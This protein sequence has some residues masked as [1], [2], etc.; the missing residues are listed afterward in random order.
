LA[1]LAAPTGSA[2]STGSPALA[3][4]RSA[5]APPALA[6]PGWEVIEDVETGSGNGETPKALVKFVLLSSYM[7]LDHAIC[8]IKRGNSVIAI[9][10]DPGNS[11]TGQQNL[12]SRL[13]QQIP[14]QH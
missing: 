8:P 13:T 10:N 4:S 14:G 12:F 9:K 6:F 3:S 1:V 11:S 5:N 2:A 7:A